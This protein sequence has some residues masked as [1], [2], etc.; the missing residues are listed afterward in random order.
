MKYVKY[1]L[2]R[3]VQMV[4]ILLLATFVVFCII[5]ISNVDEVSIIGSAKHMTDEVRASITAEYHLDESIPKQY[6]RWIGGVLTGNLGKDYKYQTSVAAMILPRIPVTLGLLSFSMLFTIVISLPLGILCAVRKNTPFDTAA[7]VITL[8]FT[9]VPEFVLSLIALILVSKLFPSYSFVGSWSGAAEYLKRILLPSAVLSAECVAFIM[10]ITRS[11]MIGQLDSNYIT[12][13]KAKG[14]SQFNIVITHAF[15]NGCLPVLTILITMI[16]TTI[17]ST[18]LVEQI[19]SLSGIGTLLVESVQTYNYPVTQ[20]LM[21]IL[22]GIFM[23]LSYIVDL[24]YT[25]LDPR[26]ELT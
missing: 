7:S 18:I 21:L 4:L 15:H 24:L 14:M 25:I 6:L 1:A 17:S 20:V 22:L 10:R 23:L 8:I 11:N 19:F 26:I 13:A 16:G 12:T 9:A 3:L 2:K 5:R